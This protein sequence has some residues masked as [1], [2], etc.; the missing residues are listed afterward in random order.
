L[1]EL[2]A[3]LNEDL[4]DALR[5]RDA[6]RRGVIQM[7]R[8]Q[9]LVER[10]KGSE[11]EIDDA[12]VLRL[13]QGHA[14]KVRE[15]LDQ[16][17]QVGREDLVEQSRKEL[18]IVSSYLPAALSADELTRLVEEIVAAQPEKNAKAM[19]AVMKEVMARAGGRADGKAV[20]AEVRKAL[21]LG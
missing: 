11:E 9:I 17:E 18:E 20:Q 3:R 4:K 16:A 15:A 8:S 2:E 13:I 1:S 14:K 12:R 5:Q 6:L 21:G 10:K 7:I 19:G